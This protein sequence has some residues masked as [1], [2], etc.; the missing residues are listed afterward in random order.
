MLISS[1]V[2]LWGTLDG[3]RAH[4]LVGSG[5]SL[6]MELPS[7]RSLS[8]VGVTIQEDGLFELKSYE[9]QADD[10]WVLEVTPGEGEGQRSGKVTVEGG[11]TIKGSVLDLRGHSLVVD[12]GGVITA[13]AMGLEEGAG[14]PSSD[15]LRAGA[16]Y[17]GLGSKGSSD[18]SVGTVYGS[19]HRPIAFGSG[20]GVNGAKGGGILRLTV[21]TTLEVEGVIQAN[22]APGTGTYN[23]GASGGSIWI[24]TRE[25]EGEG[26]IQVIGGSG[27]SSGGGGGGGRLAV[28]YRT[29][30]WWFGRLQA[31]GGTGYNRGP[32]G[33]GT[34]Y[35]EILPPA[36]RNRTLIIDNL[37][38]P[39]LVETIT[40]E[41]YSQPS[42][43]SSR[44]WLLD[45]DLDG[46]L[47]FEHVRIVNQSHLVAE[48]NLT[49]LRVGTFHS[50]HTSFLHIGNGQVFVASFA[51]DAEFDVNVHVYEGGLLVLPPTFTCY[52]VTIVVRGTISIHDLT[53]GQGCH[54]LLSQT[55]TSRLL[56]DSLDTSLDLLEGSL[57]GHYRFDSLT[58]AADGEVA[59]VDDGD[60]TL[61]NFTLSVQRLK[62][63]G[64]GHLHAT[65]MEINAD[66]LIVDDLGRVVADVHE[67]PCEEE[68]GAGKDPSGSYGGSGAGHG[69]RGGRS[70][71]QPK[72][73][74]AYG[75]VL[76]PSHMGCKGGGP[77]A[78]RGAGKMILNI[79]ETLKIDGEIIADG[80][81]STQYGN[82]GG[83]GGS[84]WIKT[85][86]MQGYGRVSVNG[87]AGSVY[88]SY[89]G[90]GG[91]AGR[92]AVYFAQNRTFSGSFEAHG[93]LSGGEQAGVGGPG[94]MFFYHTGYKHR[95]LI[96]NN[97]GRGPKEDEN[98]ISD[99]DDL[100][101]DESRAWL[102][103]SSGDHDLAGD[104]QYYF[105]EFQ[106]YGRAHLAIL[107]DP[108]HS[109][110]TIY[111]ENMIGDRTGTLHIANNQ[112]VDLYRP[113][114]D[115]PFNVH[116]YEGGH[117][118]LAPDTVVHGV[119]IFLNGAL[120]HINTLI[121]HHGGRFWLNKDGHTGDLPSGHYEFDSIHVQDEGYIHMISDPVQDLGMNLTVR[122]LQVDGGGLVEC[123]HLYVRAEVITIDAGGRLSANGTGYSVLNGSSLNPDGSRREGLHGVINPGLGETGSVGSS[124]AGHGGSG[125][126]GY[127][128][129]ETGQPYSDLYEPEEFGSAGGGPKGGSGGGRIWF[130]VT[131]A[132]LIDGIVSANGNDGDTAS[133]N[134]GGGSAGSIWMHCAKI[135]GYGTIATNGG[136]GSSRSGGGAGGRV[137]LYF[138]QNDTANGFKYESHGGAPGIDCE[139]CEGG[140]PGTVFLYH[141]YH[142]HRTLFLENA[143]FVP[144]TKAIDWDNLNKDGCRAWILPFSGSH[145]FAGGSNEFHFEELQIYDGAHMA[146][147][148]T[149]GSQGNVNLIDELNN[150]LVV[151]PSRPRLVT[152]FFQHMIGD[153]S[154]TIHVGDLQEMDLERE[155]IDLPFSVH[156]YYDGHLGLAPKTVVHGVEVHMAG[157]LSHIQNLT[158][159]H[160]GYMWLQHGGRT[161]GSPFSHY[162]FQFVRV[163]DDS[164]IEA[165]TDPISEPGI[166]FKVRVFAIE[167]GGLYHG[168][169]LTI[170][171]ENI[172]VDD[173]G[174][175]AA[176]ALGYDSMHRNDTHF[177]LSLHG[178]VNPGMP[179]LNTG[180]GS[181]AGHGGSGGISIH[182]AG[183]T[184]G[185][186]YGDLYEPYVFG[187]AG[188]LGIN[189][190]SG[191]RGG[192]LIWMNVTDTIEIDGQVTANG[193]SADGNG[194]GGGSG[195][196]VWVYCHTIK[197][198][199]RFALNGG[200]GSTHPTSPGSGGAGGRL[201]MYF[202]NN[203]TASGFNYH[204]RGGQAGHPNL[205]ENGGAGTAFLYH[206][207]YEHRT[208]I[209]DNGG[210]HPLDP[211][212]VIDTYSDLTL[213]RCRTWFLPQSGGHDFA[214][215]KFDFHFEELQI[216]G[217]AHVA[218]LT[219]P[220]DTNATLFFL[221]M[222]G[223]RSG[224]FHVGR[225][226]ELDLFRPEIDLPFSA[227]VYAGGFLG[228]APFTI[229][230]GVS[231]W[232]HGVL[233]HIENMTLHHGGLLSME[234]GGR[235]WHDDPSHYDFEIVRI[236]D[237]STI[238]GLTEPVGHPGI[239]FKAVA[240]FVE[241]G[242]VFHGTRLSINVENVTIDDGGSL[243][244]NGEGY[245][246]SDSQNISSGVNIGLGFSAT[247]GSSGGGH[248]GTS[249]RGEEALKTGQPYGSLY[250]PF[251]FGSAG[252][253]TNGGS[254]GGIIFLNI[255]DTFQNDGILSSEGAP[256][257]DTTSGSGSGGS[258]L[259]E[260]SLIKGTGVVS[261]N[262]GNQTNTAGG[263]GS[264]GRTALYFHSNQT[265]LG[266]FESHGGRAMSP[267]ESGGPGTVF[268]YHQGHQHRTLLVENGNLESPYIVKI[269]SHSDISQ[270]SFKAWLLPQSGGHHLAGGS[271]DYHFEELQ[272][273]G[274]AH[275]AILTD[276]YDHG[277]T[278]HFLHMIGDRSGVVHIGPN[279]IMDLRRDFIDIPFSVYIYQRGYLG[280]A[281]DTVLSYI[282]ISVEGRLDHI[283]NMTMYNGASLQ[284]HLTGSTND[285]PRL[286]Y[287]FNGTVIVKANSVMNFSAPFAHPEQ[288]SLHADN[289][290]VEGG[291]LV[292]AKN[293]KIECDGNMTVDDG[294]NVDVSDGGYLSD[295]GQAPGVSHRLGNSGASHGGM[296]GRG[297]CGGI[298]SCRLKR[299]IPYGNLLYPGAFGSGGAGPRGG[300]GG[301]ILNIDVK[302]I[303]RVDGHIKANS[304]DI[305]VASS[306]SGAS[307]GSGGSILIQTGALTGGHTGAI[308]SMGGSG[309]A[310]GGSGSGGRIT[311]YHT[312]NVT[313]D[314]FQGAYNVHGGPVYSSAE[315]GA[316]GTFYLKNLGTELSVLRVDN[317]GRQSIDNEVENIGWRLDLSN[318]PATYSKSSSFTSTSGVTVTSSSSVYNRNPYYYGNPNDGTSYL[319]HYLFD[320]TLND[321]F[322]QY[323]LSHDASTTLTINL[324]D[325]YFINTVRVYPV[326][327]FPTR[328]KVQSTT[329]DGV[330]KDVTSN[331]VLPSSSCHYGSY[332]DL[333]VRWNATKLTFFLS[334]TLGNNRYAAMSEIEIFV[335]GQSVHDRYK[336]R[337]LSS[338][339]TWIE[340]ETGT[341]SYSF[342]ELYIT[343]GAQLAILP[344]GDLRTEVDVYVG[345]LF[346]DTSGYLHVGF[347]QGVSVN[348][349]HPDIPF[350]SR[351]YETGKL[352]MPSRA[353]FKGVQMK[354]SGK[355]TGIDNLYVFDGGYV[356][357]DTNGSM[358]ADSM[359]GE[360]QLASVHVQ[361]RGTFELF[362]YDKHVGM[363]MNLT[364]LTVYGGG[365]FKSN[366]RFDV[367]ALHLVAVYSGGEINLDHGGYITKD[368]RGQ[369]FEPS[370]GPGQG[371]GS[372]SGG[373]GGGHGGSGG[374]GRG[375]SFI[376]LAYGSIYNPVD[377]G[378]TG[379]YGQQYAL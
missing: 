97:I 262:G 63:E 362:S 289:L 132:I 94:T 59:S 360:I 3:A 146:V 303:L 233:A 81:S 220:V 308:Q 82:G 377:Y 286:K 9:G 44:T 139:D 327:R 117:L 2:T 247:R 161:T 104:Q 181:G 353:F 52:N 264:G 338:A 269:Q 252:G 348:V 1:H 239:S 135:K 179:D 232:L 39:P 292:Y 167:G 372:T 121:L 304:L 142:D 95:T 118:G 198:Y 24:T 70:T 184:S 295:L 27:G 307:G 373:S 49:Q 93:G 125:G 141:L 71:H 358:G 191:G 35:L 61:E 230:H 270:D 251:E 190:A 21:D 341:N 163:Q 350:N 370:E 339:R 324:E 116:V 33:A 317:D 297:A 26:Q 311:V 224:T 60:D 18:L 237:N 211:L 134:N 283:H 296:G 114:I 254:G 136:A 58:I 242:G 334:S 272:I 98:V 221:Y 228:L 182:S 379:G 322:H 91:S 368:V 5:G 225:N 53:I 310:S 51:D 202:V 23:G 287:R 352:H 83:S 321:D 185:F 266:R 288:Y 152:L 103:P 15:G 306:L 172:T 212:N 255:S 285:L 349:T 365:L 106:L 344:D 153:R 234:H 80:E 178:D 290:V 319:I 199:G 187:S 31:H 277:A 337:E 342:D 284:S 330:V 46:A 147:L 223:D 196:S 157:L 112:S 108:P 56:S 155:E 175:L 267:A 69:G 323:F 204:S 300:I 265:F 240:L 137:A 90:G 354:T 274:N 133:S 258:I 209:V 65:R 41:Q 148:A 222:I 249:G 302:G 14:A 281:P 151:A 144:R 357:I 111:F 79:A 278:L 115:L 366:D 374:R 130:N 19:L 343:G 369:G 66:I 158:L 217:A 54:L 99:Y 183:R 131:D 345:E 363:E 20:G 250:E 169:R 332:A 241:G 73:G 119:T 219:E 7:T 257:G 12:S 57:A 55:G 45:D 213:D 89:Q 328:F 170:L 316:S 268:F 124:G 298:I 165:T 166:T 50:D 48:T 96:V 313:H 86:L 168:T 77:K 189:S 29:M 72:T 260:C 203:E 154:G 273:Y 205:A 263:S 37:N 164:K 160:G 76:E 34:V 40:P 36:L 256:G 246:V 192:G 294:G 378:S 238:L 227:R 28:Y 261:V 6:T 243:N 101:E 113:T 42:L 30:D 231:I 193:G 177:H 100:S 282:F 210:L 375:Q 68:D 361:D 110:A 326:C 335:D 32:G 235:T 122:S 171:A 347:S 4:L 299:N 149:N 359:P 216:Y 78:G 64:G 11:G 305:G 88:N 176:D 87:G 173:G 318:T 291:G 248:G 367:T 280:L 253:G 325:D 38:Q 271:H 92:L 85:N 25:M 226:Q 123:T 351:I 188:G 156:V 355:V 364:N 245:S 43:G 22:G 84:I 62:V 140:G 105:E 320:Q 200:D 107:T 129:E 336:Y 331:Y 244:V 236:Q 109:N 201:A 275:L 356:Y 128:V 314:F 208:L 279:Q 138:M 8:F 195:G 371:Y 309:D 333:P 259:I 102:L 207:V 194:G 162:E 127:G 120:S 74:A 214:N 13:N 312:S 159:H 143:G 145:G 276:P 340:P 329:S 218:I 47:E 293:L 197:G 17:G 67:I 75:H 180:L 126:H 150:G 174:Q 16:G 315:A 206:M 346:G 376:G 215:S 10:P 229:V 186:A 301:G